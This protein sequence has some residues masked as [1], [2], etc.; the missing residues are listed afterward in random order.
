[1]DLALWDALGILRNEPVWQMIGG[2]VRDEIHFYCTGPEPTM[3]D[4]GFW[5]S[6]VPLPFGPADGHEG[7]EQNYQFL[8]KHRESV[9]NDFPLMVDCYMALTVQYA[10]ALAKKCQDLNINWWEEVLHPDD[11]DGFIQIKQAHPDK[12]WT[13]G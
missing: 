12:K 6:K 7:L 5:G 11:I 10:I 2:K 3:R 4:M 9:P 8:K 1:M 13:T